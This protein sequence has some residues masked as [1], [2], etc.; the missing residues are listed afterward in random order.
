MREE[1]IKEKYGLG[2]FTDRASLASTSLLSGNAADLLVFL[3]LV[4]DGE[5]VVRQILARQHL[6]LGLWQLFAT[7][8]VTFRQITVPK[9]NRAHYSPVKGL[10]V[11]LDDVLLQNLVLENPGHEHT[12]K[13]L[14]GHGKIIA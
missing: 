10:R 1:Y 6:D 9:R 3:W 7:H 14:S 4:D 11:P 2:R 8:P 13:E 5:N 12:G